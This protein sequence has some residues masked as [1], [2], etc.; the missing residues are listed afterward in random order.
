MGSVGS[1][2]SELYHHINMKF[3]VALSVLVAMAY[4][5]ADPYLNYAGYH[6]YAGLGYLGY[7][8][9]LKAS[10]CVNALNVP[11]PCAGYHKR[12]AEA[13]PA[14]VYSGLGYPYGAVGPYAGFGYAAHALVAPHTV[15]APAVLGTEDAP[16]PVHAVAV[17]HPFGYGVPSSLVGV[18]T[19]VK[20]E[21]VAC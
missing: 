15:V 6:G 1:H 17:T 3:L 12:E 4:A 8:Y 10:P 13:D 11:V 14:L 21:Q 2:R 18:C 5:D 16:N 20:G 19:N 7:P 9:G